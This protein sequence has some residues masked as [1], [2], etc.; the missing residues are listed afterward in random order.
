MKIS[1]S[2]WMGLVVVLMAA[3]TS[4]CGMVSQLLAT[5]TPT[6]TNTPTVTNTATATQTPTPTAT[7][8]AT[9]TPTSTYTPTATPTPVPPVTIT[10]CLEA[11]DCPNASPILSYFGEDQVVDYGGNYP[12]TVPADTPLYFRNGWCAI[13]MNTL[14]ENM[15]KYEFIFTIDGVSYVNLL[16]RGSTLSPDS[17]A[18]NISYPC[19]SVGGA[20][21]GWKADESHTIIIGGRV[22]AELSDG[23]QTYPPGEEV[24]QY[25]VKPINATATPIPTN[26]PTPR[27]TSPPVPYV[28]PAPACGETGK[29]VINNATNGVMTI[30]LS[31]PASYSYQLPVGSNTLEICGG[32]YTYTAYGCGGG[33]IS[34]K[35]GTSVDSYHKFTCN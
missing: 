32:S 17:K 15:Q 8:T 4:G 30:I 34:G 16:A 24:I 6:P 23:W 33:S 5:A 20:L 19:M 25:T 28:P 35:I 7:P 26:T 10:G 3:A 9:A 2:I 27:P 1:K 14:L 12:V 29:I 11:Q 18:P 31:G 21:S 13:D 22:T